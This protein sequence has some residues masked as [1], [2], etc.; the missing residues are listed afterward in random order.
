MDSVKVNFPSNVNV[1]FLNVVNKENKGLSDYFSIRLIPVQVL[2]DFNGKEVFRHP[3][4]ITYHE[5]SAELRSILSEES[6]HK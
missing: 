6:G 2:L 3:G 5:L 4:Y 1:I